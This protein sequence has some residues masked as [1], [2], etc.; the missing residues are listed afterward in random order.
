[1]NL[2][3]SNLRVAAVKPPAVYSRTALKKL[4]VTLK[5]VIRRALA[6]IIVAV[7]NVAKQDEDLHSQE[8]FFWMTL[9]NSSLLEGD[10]RS[11]AAKVHL[12]LRAVEARRVALE[13]TARS[14]PEWSLLQYAAIV[15]RRI[16]R[17][18][19]SVGTQSRILPIKEAA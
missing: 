19:H 16:V 10:P 9:Y 3:P 18:A 13:G 11:F 4:A 8:A 12:A 14:A 15:L 5:E 1:L 6:R 17:N 2:H 7:E